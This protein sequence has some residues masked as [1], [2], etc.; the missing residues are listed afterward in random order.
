MRN[1]IYEETDIRKGTALG[2]CGRGFFPHS[3]IIK[4]HR[5]TLF[6]IERCVYS[7]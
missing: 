7:I 3:L 2:Q 4:N 1:V 6:L 5:G